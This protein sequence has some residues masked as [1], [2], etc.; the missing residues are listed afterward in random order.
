MTEGHPQAEAVRGERDPEGLRGPAAETDRGQGG[1]RVKTPGRGQRP[2]RQRAVAQGELDED[3]GDQQAERKIEGGAPPHELAHDQH[4][5]Q[6][7]E[8]TGQRQELGDG[9]RPAAIG[10]GGQRSPQ[11]ECVKAGATEAV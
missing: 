5:K 4:P 11:E 7:A 1:R 6:P 3:E 10:A 9:Q 8:E 2:S